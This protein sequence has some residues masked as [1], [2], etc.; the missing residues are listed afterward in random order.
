MY[1]RLWFLADH[2]IEVLYASL[3]AKSC[4]GV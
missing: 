4:I 2:S 1:D 3:R